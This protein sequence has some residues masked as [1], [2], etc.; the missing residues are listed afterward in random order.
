MI[1]LTS[2]CFSS[3]CLGA[4]AEKFLHDLVEAIRFLSSISMNSCLGVPGP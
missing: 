2:S 1:S 3:G 4:Q